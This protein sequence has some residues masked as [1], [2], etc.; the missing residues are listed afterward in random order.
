[1]DQARQTIG[2]GHEPNKQMG[3]SPECQVGSSPSPISKWAKPKSN[4]QIGPSLTN[5]QAQ[6]HLKPIK[7]LYK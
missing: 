7:F 1:M 3:P 4:R 2:P 5:K 6:A